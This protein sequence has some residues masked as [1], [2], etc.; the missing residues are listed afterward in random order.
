MFIIRSKHFLQKVASVAITCSCIG[1][2]QCVNPPSIAR[3][4]CSHQVGFLVWFDLHSE[5]LRVARHT[6][7]PLFLHCLWITEQPTALTIWFLHRWW[8][9]EPLPF[10]FHCPR[11]CMVVSFIENAYI[12]I[13]ASDSK[14]S[15]W[16]AWTVMNNCRS[17]FGWQSA[18]LKESAI[19][20]VVERHV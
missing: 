18:Q 15:F 16:A 20:R 4:R 11:M 10:Y 5:E 19:S 3:M 2:D 12:A 13:L 9:A 17:Q 7:G 14:L 8:E 6:T 1:R